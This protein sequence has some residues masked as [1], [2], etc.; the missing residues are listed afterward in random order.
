MSWEAPLRERA[1]LQTA[2]PLADFEDGGSSRLNCLSTLWI[3]S[4]VSKLVSPHTAKRF[5]LI[6]L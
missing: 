4:Y 6:I 3:V 1:F 2:F 5:S